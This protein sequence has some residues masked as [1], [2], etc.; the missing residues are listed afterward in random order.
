MKIGTHDSIFHADDVVACA[1]IVA[2]LG[3]HDKCTVIRSRDP[4]VL[5]TCDIL[6]DVGG[7]SNGDT[8]FDHHQR[9]GAGARENGVPYASAGLAWKRFGLAYIAGWIQDAT[10]DQIEKIWKMV[11]ERV[12]ES[13]DALDCG[14][15]G[16]PTHFT[17][18][19]VLSALNPANGK[20][21]DEAF[22]AA[23]DMAEVILNSL[24]EN[25]L[26]E[27]VDREVI[28]KTFEA[29]TDGVAVFP[30]FVSGITQGDVPWHIK[31]VIYPSPNN[32]W[33]VQQ[34]PKEPGSFEGRVPLLEDWAGLRGED[35]AKAVGFEKFGVNTFC[36][37]GR[38][39]GGAETL[40]DAQLMATLAIEKA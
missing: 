14:F 28:E 18:S 26:K 30:E 38:F 29:T 3:Y 13:I 36:H 5:A 25:Y 33:M 17:F 27:A 9:G 20:N 16:R 24:I 2:A 19:G 21:I 22:A 39:I 6:V 31:M 35:L 10:D 7:E 12:M 32:G 40:E 23:M 15:G 11:D 34:I 8:R 1:I 4:E 37:A